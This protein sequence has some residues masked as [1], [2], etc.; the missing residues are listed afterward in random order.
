MLSGRSL[1]VWLYCIAVTGAKDLF[2]HLVAFPC[3]VLL[4]IENNVIFSTNIPLCF[5]IGFSGEMGARRTLRGV[6]YITL[7]VTSL[8][9]QI[10]N[11]VI[12]KLITSLSFTTGMAKVLLLKLVICMVKE[13]EGSQVTSS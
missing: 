1:N 12:T 5:I 8:G 10:L 7:N 3:E 2:N 6:N 13:R 11:G 4:K 9:Y